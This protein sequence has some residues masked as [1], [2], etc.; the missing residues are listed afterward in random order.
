MDDAR[1]LVTP[2]DDEAPLARPKKSQRSANA[3][4]DKNPYAQSTSPTPSRRA[5]TSLR[6]NSSSRA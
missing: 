3:S 5:L 1:P 2:E 6:D 4:S